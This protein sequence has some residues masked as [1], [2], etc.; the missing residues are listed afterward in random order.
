VAGR[1][2]G[3]RRLKYFSLIWISDIDMR[4]EC[5][6]YGY[7]KLQSTHRRTQAPAKRKDQDMTTYIVRWT[8]ADKDYSSQVRD[9]QEA[10]RLAAA[11]A[12]MGWTVTITETTES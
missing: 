8:K 10:K 6:Y 7:L 3:E 9:P 12:K 5:S 2:G 4:C 11:M 1:G